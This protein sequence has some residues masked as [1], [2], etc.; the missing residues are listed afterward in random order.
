MI[1]FGLSPYF[2]R[3]MIQD[4]VKSDLPFSL[5][6]DETT[7]TQVKKWVDL[8][9]RYWSPTHEEV[10]VAYYTSL[11]FGHAEGDTVV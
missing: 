11:F 9:L 5:H 6:F 10:W 2:T 3:K 1:S 4:L 7:N 8:I